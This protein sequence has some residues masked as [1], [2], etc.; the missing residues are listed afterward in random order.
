MLSFARFVYLVSTLATTAYPFIINMNCNQ[1]T[2]SQD[3]ADALKDVEEVAKAAVAAL[4]SS[5]INGR[6]DVFKAA[7]DPL[8]YASDQPGLLATFAKLATLGSSPGLTVQI[9]CRENHIRYHKGDPKSYWEDTDYYSKVNNK[10][11]PIGAAPNSQNKPGS[12][13]SYT[14]LGYK[15]NDQYDCSGNSHIFLAPQRL[16]PPAGLDR[17]LRRYPTIVKDGLDGTHNK[18]EDIKP[19]AQTVL[20][21]LLHAVGDLSAPD[22]TTK[23]RN[24]LINDGPSG[25]K[26]Y[27]WAHCNSRRIQNENN[28]NLA[29]CITFLA[30]AIYLQIEGKDTYW[31]TGEVDP[32]T[33]RPKQIP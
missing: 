13:G 4:T 2:E 25:A 18:I 27:G 14:T 31:T 12:K 20:H 1:G 6:E 33:L 9:Y 16:H 11:M 22:P 10:Q 3:V 7:Y 30:Q 23:K 15:F 29:D 28:N 26:V 24:Q 19:L 5:K 8:M 17:D 21:E 32:K